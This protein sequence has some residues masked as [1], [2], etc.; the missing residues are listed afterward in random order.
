MS[1]VTGR[2]AEIKQPRGGYIKPSMFSKA[3]MYDDAVLAENENLHGT[4]V[5]L[6]V[7]YM[8]RFMMTGH[9][10]G[11]FWTSMAGYFRYRILQAMTITDEDVIKS[12][13]LRGRK[14]KRSFDEV[15][16]TLVRERAGENAAEK[17]LERIKGLDDDSIIAACKLVTYDTWYRNFFGAMLAKGAAETN[18]DES[19][20]NNIRIIIQRCLT[21]WEKFGPIVEEHFTFEGDGTETGYTDTVDSGDGDYLTKDT[22]WDLKVS[23][24]EPK[25][26]HTLQLLMYYIMG[27]HSGMDVYKDIDKLGI[28]NPRLNTV[29]ILKVEDI[30]AEIIKTVEDEVICY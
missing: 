2:I 16:D 1:S 30:P 24:A 10:S 7:D 6:A 29:Y 13:L 5:G 11:A 18:P 12:G 26:K 28:F 9:A 27:K 21:F 17:L 8:T 15:R 19:T 20:I 3:V 22:M 25:N 14:S 23:K 4:I